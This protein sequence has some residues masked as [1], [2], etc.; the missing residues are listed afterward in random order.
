MSVQFLDFQSEAWTP[1][2]REGKFEVGVPRIVLARKAASDLG[3]G[4]GDEL[5]LS[6]PKTTDAGTFTVG[7]TRLHVLAIH[8]YPLRS[9]AYIDVRQ[10]D[11]IGLAGFAN[12]VTATPA[13]G[14][15]L[16]DAKRQLFDVLGVA[17]DQGLAEG[18][19]AIAVL[20]EQ[21][22]AIFLV[23]ASVILGLALLIALN[24]ANI[25]VE[26]R[27]RDH[28]TMFAYG[29]SVGR[30][31]S[32]L[33]IEGLVVGTIATLIGIALGYGLLLWMIHSLVPA[34][35]PELGVAFTVDLAQLALLLI[36]A[37]SVIAIA[38]VLSVR[39]LQR[40]DIHST[41]RVME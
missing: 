8:G 1:T 11:L 39:K 33:V 4:I 3:V 40:M 28:A 10:A 9:V 5:V 16:I 20:F 19:K 13:D 34:T 12:G 22:A 38:P 26:E 32:N 41:L 21:F 35:Y 27:A 2:A 24:T 29:V 23:I 37:I 6:H 31:V 14:V 25:N 15:T 36:L 7:S 30:V 18:F 17:M